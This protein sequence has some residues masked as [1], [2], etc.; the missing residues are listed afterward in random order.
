MNFSKIKYTFGKDILFVEKMKS[1]ETDTLLFLES[2]TIP[3]FKIKDKKLI[4]NSDYDF[5]INGVKINPKDI[6]I[7]GFSV[8][9]DDS[10]NFTLS[11]KTKAIHNVLI[12]K[13]DK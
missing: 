9:G 2:T 13:R 11:I 8:L 5:K 4:F 10:I 3:I 6:S 1:K 12:F 7:C